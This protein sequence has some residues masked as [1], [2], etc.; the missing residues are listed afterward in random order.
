MTEQEKIQR[1]RDICSLMCRYLPDTEYMTTGLYIEGEEDYDTLHDICYQF[2]TSIEI[3]TLVEK[4]FKPNF[5][6]GDL[7]S[8]YWEDD[9]D[10]FGW[11]NA[12]VDKEELY[13]QFGNSD[14]QSDYNNVIIE[15][16]FSDNALERIERALKVF[17][18]TIEN[19]TIYASGVY[20]STPLGEASS[21]REYKLLPTG[22][23]QR[24]RAIKEIFD[25]VRKDIQEGTLEV[26]KNS[27]KYLDSRVSLRVDN[28][29]VILAMMYI[30]KDYKVE[31]IDLMEKDLTEVKAQYEL[32]ITKD[33]ADFD[34]LY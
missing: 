19:K 17:K 11:C 32:L 5:N 3:S 31:I 14:T 1:M 10:V 7:L 21:W 4:L 9:T 33:R 26:K 16:I 8:D 30:T 34:E 22:T 24:T 28:G 27:D 29:K 18:D 25:K 2:D 23:Y 12:I 13:I 6:E 20:Y 15:E